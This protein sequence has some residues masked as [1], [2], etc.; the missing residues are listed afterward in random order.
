LFSDKHT[1]GARAA[2]KELKKAKGHD[3]YT[4]DD[5]DRAAKCGKFPYR[6]SDL[7]LKASKSLAP[8]DP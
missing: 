5:L 7:F 8:I 6:P 4:H 3:D 2:K 1:A